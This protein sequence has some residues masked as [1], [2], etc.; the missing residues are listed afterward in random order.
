M[1]HNMVSFSNYPPSWIIYFLIRSASDRAT[2][3]A[4]HLQNLNFEKGDVVCGV[5][6]VVKRTPNSVALLL[7]APESYKGPP[8]SG[9]IVSSIEQRGEETVFLNDV[10]LWR[11]KSESPVPLEGGLGKWM[12]SIIAMSLVESSTQKLMKAAK[13]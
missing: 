11:T 9:M 3:A 5:Y 2:F 1:R 6:R 12:H 4:T 10:F 13:V 8:A 7:D